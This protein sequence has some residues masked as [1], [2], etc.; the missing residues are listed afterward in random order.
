MPLQSSLDRLLSTV[1][2]C[3]HCANDLPLGP[4]PVL[5]MHADVRILIAGQAPG[6]IVH[7]GRADQTPGQGS[8]GAGAVQF[9][10]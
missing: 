4:R 3:T 5:Q 1:H 8:I 10:I 2:A 7:N 9:V 6:R